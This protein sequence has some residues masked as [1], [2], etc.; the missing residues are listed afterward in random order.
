MAES[1]SD[2]SEHGV[3]IQMSLHAWIILTT[4]RRKAELRVLVGSLGVVMGRPDPGVVLTDSIS[5]EHRRNAEIQDAK[6][7]GGWLNIGGEWSERTWVDECF[8][9]A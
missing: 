3:G 8:G 7:S 4:M 5:S 9:W 2:R 6:R 1:A